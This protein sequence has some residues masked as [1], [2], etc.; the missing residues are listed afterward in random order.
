MDNAEVSALVYLAATAIVVGFQLL[1]ALGAPWGAYA[2][3]GSFPGRLPPFMRVL[4]VVQ[5][6]VLGLLAIVVLSAAGLLVPELAGGAPWPIWVVVAVT[7]VGVTLNL[8]S[9]SPGARRIWMPVSAVLL[10]LVV[11]GGAHRGVTRD[12]H[13]VAVHS[14]HGATTDPRPSAGNLPGLRAGPHRR[15]ASVPSRRGPT[16]RRGGTGCPRRG[17]P[18]GATRR[19]PYPRLASPWCSRRLRWA[20]S[21]AMRSSALV[22]S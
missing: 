15:R 22:V 19:P 4:A 8:A 9:R 12:R 18:T 6:V 11:H 16:P 20:S 13:A 5:A 2:M 10:P 7:A 1:L 17:I 21:S 3:G 14:E